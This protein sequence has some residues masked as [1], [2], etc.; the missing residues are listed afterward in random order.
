MRCL[1]STATPEF[2]A[3]GKRDARDGLRL[4]DDQLIAA[5]R[6]EGDS[7][8]LNRLVERHLPRVRALI[9]GMLLDD[10]A[11][12]DL[13]Q[14]ALLRACRHLGSFNG[15]SQFSTWLYRIAMNAAH[16]HLRRLQKSPVNSRA[17]LP[18]A[19]EASTEGPARRLLNRELA[20]Q[21]DLALAELSPS[22]RSAV[23]LTILEGFTPQEAARIEGC[24]AAT[25][26][27]RVHQAR[28]KLH[29]LLNRYLSE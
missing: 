23:V 5:F 7:H 13:T 8:A 12:D 1:H 6:E 19:Q 10:A 26:Y 15:T 20:D 25:M 9:Y 27:W 3:E 29:T 11:A 24:S 21:I 4:T 17:K 28:R 18:P 2:P 16:D 14:E 22:L